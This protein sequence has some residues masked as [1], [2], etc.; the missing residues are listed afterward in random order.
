MCGDRASRETFAGWRR[1][2][3]VSV[4]R[5]TA[6]PP[7]GTAQSLQEDLGDRTTGDDGIEGDRWPVA[8]AVA[9]VRVQFVG[10]GAERVQVPTGQHGHW[11]RAVEDQVEICRPL[12]G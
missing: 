3:S 1:S 7:A 12:P 10:D 11:A 4:Q 5:P 2:A 6:A 8:R 9:C